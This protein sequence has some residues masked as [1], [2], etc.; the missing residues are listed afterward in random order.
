MSHWQTLLYICPQKRIYRGCVRMGDRASAQLL[1]YVTPERPGAP[2]TD[3]KVQ[4][5]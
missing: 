1:R 5:L 3:T 4:W 2:S